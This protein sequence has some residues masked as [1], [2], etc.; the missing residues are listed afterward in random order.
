MT[1]QFNDE[2]FRDDY[3]FHNSDWAIKRFPFPFHEDSYM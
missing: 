1:I 3:S 2:T